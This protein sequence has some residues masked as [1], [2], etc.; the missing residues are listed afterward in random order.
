MSYKYVLKNPPYGEKTLKR[1]V[2]QYLNT[3]RLLE[4]KIGPGNNVYIDLSEISKGK[5]AEVKLRA[6]GMFN[7]RGQFKKVFRDPVR[8][9][10]AA[11]ITTLN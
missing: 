10:V 7:A 6:A 9:K 2:K 3:K 5:K 8:K 1:L 4:T 11:W